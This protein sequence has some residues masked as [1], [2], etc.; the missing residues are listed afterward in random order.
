MSNSYK[1][2]PPIG[3]SSLDGFVQPVT[4]LSFD[5]VSDIL[6]TGL[7]SGTVNSYFGCRGVRGP[8]F[9]VGGNLSVKKITSGDNTVQAFGE[10]GDG[11]GSW[12]KGGVNKWFYRY[13]NH[14]FVDHLLNRSCR[15]DTNVVTFSNTSSSSHTLAVSLTGSELALLSPMTG[16]CIRQVSTTSVLTQLELSHSM[17]LSGSL[18]GY[19]RVH[20]PRT[21]MGRS[22]GSQN[23]VKAHTRSV[24]G[25]QAVGNFIFSIGMGE[26]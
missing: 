12:S 26:R 23:F 25:L 18:D 17:L 2:I 22:S 16:T 19:L 21:G 3:T 1:S 4:A 13:V 6:W 11:L 14:L 9:R 7:D 10:A 24:Q 5:P 15:P 8:S 20:D